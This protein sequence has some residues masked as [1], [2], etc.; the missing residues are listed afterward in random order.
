MFSI[1][2]SLIRQDSSWINVRLSKGM[3][4]RDYYHHKALNSK[5]SNHWSRHKEL[6]NYVNREVK[7]CKSEY[8]SK[9]ITENKSN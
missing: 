2:K 7:K 4:Q 1:F 5:F 6:K 3:H 9:L 8:Y